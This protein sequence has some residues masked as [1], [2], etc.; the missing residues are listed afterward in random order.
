MK[1][2][3]FPFAG[4]SK[5]SFNGFF[6]SCYNLSI[7]EY[8]GR[9]LRIK[10]SLIKDIEKLIS[11]LL[12]KIVEEINS[13]NEYIIYG[14]SM[15][16]LVAY[17]FCVEIEKLGLKLPVKLVVSG[18][19]SPKF[20][21]ERIL[22]N[23]PNAIFWKEVSQLGGIPEELNNHPELIEYFTTILKADFRC[24][25]NYQ[26]NKNLPKL[27]I[28]IDVFFGSDEEI[29]QEESEV[30]QEE[31]TANVNVTELKGNHFFIFEHKE[32]FI[33]YFK[34]LQLNAII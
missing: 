28:P 9:G 31:T 17:L 16:A 15:G 2:I 20:S 5:H 6:T 13:N 14:H 22:S 33:N 32:F 11:E 7:L 19:K 30:W 29:T 27:T 8:P 18:A 3:F 21:R 1:I 25:E 12:P 4:G 10:E 24:I 26:Y 23:L 34:N